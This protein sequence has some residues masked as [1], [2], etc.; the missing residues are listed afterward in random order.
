MSG[1]FIRVSPTGDWKK[2]ILNYCSLYNIP[3]EHFIEVISDQKVIPMLRGKAFEFSVL[4]ALQ[5]ILPSSIWEVKKENLNAQPNSPDEDVKVIHKSTGIAIH[6]EVKSAVR[7]SF[8][9]GTPRTTIKTPHF[10]VKCHRSR[11]NFNNVLNDRYLVSD[12]DI[13]VSNPSNSLILSGEDFEM[14]S[15]NSSISFLGK[16]YGVSSPEKIFECACSNII[17]TRPQYIKES[18]KG[19]DVIPRTPLV[20]YGSD[21]N[22]DILSNIEPTLNQIIKEKITKRPLKK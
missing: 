6:I 4:D 22:W 15:D 13:I 14:I 19:H 5:H 7:G 20:R 2:D 16:H 18:H 17:F 11:S 10:R 1:Y 21:P 8:S 12:F 9:M 3:I